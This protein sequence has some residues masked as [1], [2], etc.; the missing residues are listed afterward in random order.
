MASATGRLPP[1]GASNPPDVGD[2]GGRI[3]PTNTDARRGTGEVP[4]KRPV[5]IAPDGTVHS[6]PSGNDARSELKEIALKAEEHRRRGGQVVLG[7]GLGFVGAAV[8]AT[9]ADAKALDGAPAYFFIG[10]DLPTPGSYGRWRRST[11]DLRPSTRPTQCSRDLRTTRCT[12]PPISAPRHVRT[13][14]GSPT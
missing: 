6:V 8:A 14:M 13:R 12:R 4:E 5:S 9:I 3:N 7:Q 2:D 10:I 11:P 1:A